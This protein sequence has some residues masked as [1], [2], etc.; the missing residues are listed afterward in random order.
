MSEVDI[1]NEALALL[2]ETPIRSIDESNN[3]AG[4]CKT[5]LPRVRDFNLSMQDWSFARKTAL[6]RILEDEHP[7]GAVFQIPSDC[8]TPLNLF[9]RTQFRDPWKIEGN[10]IIIPWLS[11][12]DTDA[13]V[14]LQYTAKTTNTSLFSESFKN[15]LAIDLAFRMCMPLTQDAKLYGA[16]GSSLRI[17]RLEN[18]AEDANRGDEYRFADEDPENDS[19][20]NPEE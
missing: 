4:L 3:R 20:V 10:K 12:E 16:L 1:C 6:L 9:P 7:E 15:V 13:E 18:A 14:Y 8:L 2:G 17:T 11:S 5:L 19:F